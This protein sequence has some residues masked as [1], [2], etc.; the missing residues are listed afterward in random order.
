MKAEIDSKM[1]YLSMN[2]PDIELISHK[3]RIIQHSDLA[4][5]FEH[6]ELESLINK[7]RSYKEEL[8]PAKHRMVTY[9]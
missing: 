2:A 1:Y 7:M 5:I 4:N 9:G 3:Q 8:N 6:E